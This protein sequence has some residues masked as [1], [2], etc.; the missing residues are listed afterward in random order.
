MTVHEVGADDWRAIEETLALNKVPGLVESLLEAA[1]EP[2]QE[3]TRLEDL[4]W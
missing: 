1:R 4:D 2:I 3:G